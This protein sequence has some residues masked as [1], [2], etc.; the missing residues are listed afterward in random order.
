MQ[1]LS[2]RSAAWWCIY[3]FG[4]KNTVKCQGLRRAFC[5]KE[6]YSGLGN[7]DCSIGQPLT[8][9]DVSF[10]IISTPTPSLKFNY[11]ESWVSFS[12][13]AFLWEKKLQIT[14]ITLNQFWAVWK[15]S[16]EV[17]CAISF[18]FV[19]VFFYFESPQNFESHF[20]ILRTTVFPIGILVTFLACARSIWQV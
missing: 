10:Q 13:H 6:K 11:F 16:Q 9:W 8:I 5:Y 15:H 3:W 18:V 14:L 12:S 17:R 1:F 4:L 7:S 19:S 20:R 2:C